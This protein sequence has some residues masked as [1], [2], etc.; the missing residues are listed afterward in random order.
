MTDR[1]STGS[2]HARTT[3]QPLDSGCRAS[4]VMGL[5]PDRKFRAASPELLK[6]IAKRG[7]ICPQ[8]M[9]GSKLRDDPLAFIGLG[10]TE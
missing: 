10:C 8:V 9:R 5:P 1:R 3:A 7:I 6:K 4:D 2:W